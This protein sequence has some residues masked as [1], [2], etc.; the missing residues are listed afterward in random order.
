MSLDS[1]SALVTGAAGFIGSHLVDRLLEEGATVRGLDNL[2]TGRKANIEHVV[3][4]DRFEFVDGDLRDADTVESVM[5]GVDYVFHQG[6]V[7]SVPRSVDDPLLTTEA[8]CVGTT[9]LLNSARDEG[10]EKVVVA[11]SSSVYGS[12]DKLPKHEDMPLNPESPYAL[13][14]YWTEQL[15][16]QFAKLYGLE[17]VAL[18]YFNVF[19]PRQ[20]PTSDYAAVIPKFISLM[21]DGR[22]PP[23]YGDGQQSRDFTYVANVVQANLDAATSQVSGTVLNIACGERTTVNA[24]VDQLNEIIGTKLEPRYTDPRPGDVKH[25]LADITR[26]NELI[27][28]SPTVNFDVGLN[29][30]VEWFELQS[31]SEVIEF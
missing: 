30:T 29:R 16:V 31:E 20:D 2:E 26:G 27:G 28:Y 23:I 18:R 7:P 21:L 13:S 10:V 15:A 22:R 6:A 17:T 3:G 14:K 19:G 24:L 25:S 4:H 11:S 12:S 8:N 9:N 1:S 5:D